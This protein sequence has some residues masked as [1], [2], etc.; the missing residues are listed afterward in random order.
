MTISV[1]SA[2]L[3]FISI[4][5]VLKCDFF[6]FNALKIINLRGISRIN[7]VRCFIEVRR[8]TMRRGKWASRFTGY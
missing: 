6:Q 5:I 4:Y 3:D 7:P 1:V 2:I 8:D